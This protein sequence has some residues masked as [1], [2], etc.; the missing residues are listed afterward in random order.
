MQSQSKYWV[1]TS[2]LL[3]I[4]VKAVLDGSVASGDTVYYCFQPEMCPTTERRH[5][6]GYVVFRKKHRGSFLKGLVPGAHVE[7]RKGTHEQAIAYC[8][9]EETRDG[10]T[11][12]GGQD[13]GTPNPGTRSD[14]VRFRTAVDAGATMDELYDGHIEVMARYSGFVTRYC[15]RVR[16]REFQQTIPQLVPRPGWQHDLSALL[17]HDPDPRSVIWRWDQTGNCGKSYFAMHYSPSN[18][19]VITGGKHADIHYAYSGQRVVFF[20]W[21]R[22]NMDQFP[23]ALVEQFKNG[24]F[25]VTKYESAPYRFRVPHV[26]VFANERPEWGALSSDRWDTIEIN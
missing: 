3:L 7:L 26:V 23:Y 11:V 13:P 22:K 6:Q 16:E 9:K 14:L 24:Y 4:D 1:F 15:H 17:E 21:A 2:Y 5:L 12:Y 18:S 19:F 20:D 10:D 25:L 8:S